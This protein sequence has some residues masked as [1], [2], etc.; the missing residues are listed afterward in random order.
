MYAIANYW[1]EEINFP[2]KNKI[3]RFYDSFPGTQQSTCKNVGGSA[4][5]SF[6]A[7]TLIQC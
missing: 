4:R 2:G 3:S 5:A 7:D 1:P 6:K